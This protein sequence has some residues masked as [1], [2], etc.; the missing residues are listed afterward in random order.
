MQPADDADHQAGV[1]N[2]IP[3]NNYNTNRT[4]RS[5]WM[6]YPKALI[7]LRYFLEI[8]ILK[9]FYSISLARIKPWTSKKGLL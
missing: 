4:K 3:Q 9:R 6:A 8:T 2:V 1:R 5:L 7:F